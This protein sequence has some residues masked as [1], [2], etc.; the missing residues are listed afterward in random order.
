MLN[1]GK[2][3]IAITGGSGFVGRHVLPYLK[4]KGYEVKAFVRSAEAAQKVE[5][6]G[7]LPVMC[8]MG[9]AD[10]LINAIKGSDA[11][12]HMAARLGFFGSYHSYYEDN[13][14]L[15]ERFL[16][17]SISSGVKKFIYVGAAA[18]AIGSKSP[19]PL[20][21][22]SALADRP[23]G[24]YGTTK[25]IAENVVLSGFGVDLSCIALRPPLV[26]ASDAP[27]FDS[28]AASVLK[29][30]FV[31]ID[32][33]RYSVATIHVDNLAAAIHA[34]LNSKEASGA[35][36]VSDGENIE[37]R[38][39]IDTALL[40]RGIAPPTLSIPPSIARIGGGFAEQSWRLLNLPS[41]PPITT[42]LVDLIGGEFRIDDSR[43]RDVLG[44]KNHISISEGL[45]SLKIN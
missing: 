28:I 39:L 34:G 27:V 12:V 16:K 9:N 45:A 8:D 35:F 30:Q 4:S 11:V 31:W 26:W 21:E 1:N 33:G 23:A 2:H 41:C 10:S 24:A 19:F 18:V 15:T 40:A 37:F 5:S 14:V 7:A 22:T 13:V 3:K 42:T 6:Y 38:K 32:G 17:A 29:R 25:R 20:N 44:Y 43:A 36:F